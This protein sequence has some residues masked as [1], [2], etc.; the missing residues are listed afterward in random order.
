M[1][2]F[3]KKDSLGKESG[4]PLFKEGEQEIKSRKIVYNLKTRKGKIY[5]VITKE[6]ELILLGSEVKKRGAL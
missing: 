2:A 1:T 5:D 3:G 6:G 4:N